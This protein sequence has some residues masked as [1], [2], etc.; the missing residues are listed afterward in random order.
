MT[1]SVATPITYVRPP[2]KL[3]TLLSL[4]LHVSITV[5][6]RAPERARGEKQDSVHDCERD[7]AA[8]DHRG[9]Y[10]LRVLARAERSNIH[11]TTAVGMKALGSKGQCNRGACMEGVGMV[12]SGQNGEGTK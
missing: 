12:F 2:C 7:H 3:V 6:T 8:K 1:K 11:Y 4:R 10:T 5:S 9:D